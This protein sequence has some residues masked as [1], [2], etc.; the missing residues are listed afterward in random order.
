[1]RKSLALSVAAAMTTGLVAFIP[2]TAANAACTAP[3]GGSCSDTS[4]SFTVNAGAL[5]IAAPASVTLSSATLG[6]T[7]GSVTGTLATTTVSDTRGGL[8]VSGWTVTASTTDYTTTANGGG[9]IGAAA[10]SMSSGAATIVS[11]AP[12]VVPSLSAV[13]LA[14]PATILQ[15]TSATGSNSVTY[16]PTLTVAVPT[17][18]IPGPY[19]G[20]VT[21]SVA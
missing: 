7:A 17:S 12:V 6:L 2:A 3:A 1:M 20:T 9:T 21:Q 13:N 18:A 15:A 4:V 8:G 19:T 11:G 16:T 14:A 10:A 5:S